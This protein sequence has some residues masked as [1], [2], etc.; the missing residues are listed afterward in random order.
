MIYFPSHT[1]F[2]IHLFIKHTPPHTLASGFPSPI[3]THS[4]I[5]V[6]FLI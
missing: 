4:I 6:F 3:F 2:Q 1:D 5:E